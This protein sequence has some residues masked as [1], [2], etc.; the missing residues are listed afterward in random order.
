MEVVGEIYRSWG[1]LLK[2]KDDRLE[3]KIAAYKDLLKKAGREVVENLKLSEETTAINSR[4]PP[5]SAEKLR[6]QIKKILD[7]TFWGV[8]GIFKIIRNR[9]RIR[10]LL[11]L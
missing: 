11:L 7:K 6:S 10:W 5:Y 8:G 2:A 9:H 1:W 4:F 3:P